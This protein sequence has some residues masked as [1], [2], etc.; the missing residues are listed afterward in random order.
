[1]SRRLAALDIGS[2]TLHLLVAEPA[3]GGGL[4]EILHEVVMPRIGKAVQETGRVGEAKLAEVS[5]EVRRLADLAR[6]HGAELLL[7]GATE[8]VRRAADRARVLA[9]ISEAAGGPCR[10]ISPEAEA[11]L[12]FR[13]ATAAHG[14]PGLS[15]VADIGGG[16]TECVLGEDGQIVALA[17]VPIGSGSI[18]ERWLRS[19][20]PEWAQ[21]EACAAGVRDELATAPDGDPVRGIATGGTA[22]TLPALLGRPQGSAGGD[23]TRTDLDLCRHILVNDPSAAVAQRFGIEAARARV[24]AG[25]VEIID[26]VRERYRLDAVSVS[27]QGL[28]DGMIL[29]YLEVGEAWTEG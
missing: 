13:G 9:V 29:A 15:L 1:V 10:L 16:S 24:L 11:R 17:S 18:T 14:G 8:A 5:G 22:T 20:P 7:V 25:G 23:L 27:H 4:K 19:D 26:A 3:A 28:R 2:N 12:S 6:E 21:L